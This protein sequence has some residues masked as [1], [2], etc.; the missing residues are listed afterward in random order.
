MAEPRP[1]STPS[2]AEL[3][4]ERIGADGDGVAALPSGEP[5]Y[6]PLVLPG[7]LVRADALTRRGEGWAGSATL[8]EASPE[9][10]AAPCPHFGAC[11]GCTLQHWQDAPYAAWKSDQL[12]AALARAGFADAP[13]APLARTPPGDR[14][15]VDLALAR[16]GSQV[17]VGLHRRRG[18]DVVDLQTCLVL[19]PRLV[20]LIGVLRRVLPGVTGLRRTGA[21]V[22]NLLDSGIDLLLRT[23]ASLSAADRIT[24]TALAEEVGACRVSW[25]LNAGPPEP[26]C[27]LHKAETMLAGAIVAP[28]PGA[29]LQASLAGEAAITAAVLA[30]LP[31]RMVARA[32]IVELFAGCGTLTF[33]LAEQARVIAYE[34]DK[35]AAEALR[36]AVMGRRVE[37]VSRDLARQPLS[38]KELAGA[39]AIVL[40]P[41]FTGA[42]AQMPGI[43]A[44]GVER[45]IYVSCNPA[46][47][48]RDARM[49]RD[50][51]Y[52][53]AS[54]APVD[55]FLW[56]AQ[57][58]SV[59]VFERV[60]RRG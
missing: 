17:L 43:A 25:A 55:Q 15:R 28:P 44:S 7:E 23:D 29:F 51:G 18:T 21:A 46:A 47:L 27:S 60:R 41:P 30:G 6:L 14:R 1:A 40:D 8:L 3:R 48:A 31:A 36:R 35:A 13:L 10:Q 52:T 56:S 38:V 39:A 54:A 33:A 2:G 53:V 37:A 16:E 5:V 19:T 50:G 24:L 34:G 20:S 58:E 22:V 11:G 57:V 9:R 45:V 59:T 26:A 12:R 32:R 42:A 49:L 4:V